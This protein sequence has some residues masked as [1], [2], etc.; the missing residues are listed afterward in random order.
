MSKRSFFDISQNFDFTVYVKKDS[1]QKNKRSR[2]QMT[3][4]RL[5]MNILL[6]GG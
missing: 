6:I 5:F 3:C 4:E 1:E 2:D